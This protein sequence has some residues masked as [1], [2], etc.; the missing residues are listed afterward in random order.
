MDVDRPP[1]P[2]DVG[3]PDT[4]KPDKHWH[5]IGQK[6]SIYMKCIL[7]SHPRLNGEDVGKARAPSPS[8]TK[9]SDTI[10]KEGEE[11]VRV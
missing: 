4:T 6:V 7:A 8:L 1:C 5:Q 11:E 10:P 9:A 3:S 2:M